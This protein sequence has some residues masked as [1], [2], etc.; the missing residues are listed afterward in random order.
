[1]IMSIMVYLDEA[2]ISG[3]VSGNSNMYKNE[4]NRKQQE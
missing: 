1:M 4:L 3:K 2:R